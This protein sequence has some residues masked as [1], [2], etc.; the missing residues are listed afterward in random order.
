MLYLGHSNI[1]DEGHPSGKAP[2]QGDESALALYIHSNL[3]HNKMGEKGCK[4]LSRELAISQK[5]CS[6]Y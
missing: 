3:A 4:G 6:W 5:D 2:S 1:G